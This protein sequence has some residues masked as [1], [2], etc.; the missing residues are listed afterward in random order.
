MPTKLGNILRAAEEYPLRYGLDIS[1]TF[2]RLWLLL[3][4]SNQKELTEARRMMD[5]R[6]ELMIWEVLLLVWLIFCPLL[7]I[8]VA[9]IVIGIALLISYQFVMD[10]AKVYADLIRATY[11]LHRFDLY[12]QLCWPIPNAPNEEEACGKALQKFIYQFYTP[13]SIT[14]TKPTDK[15]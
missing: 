9:V 6:V 15:E 1:T 7:L 13:S 11:D 3:P 8:P 2:P 12:K 4:E 14:F 5:F 10:A